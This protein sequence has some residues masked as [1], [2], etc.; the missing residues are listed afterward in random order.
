MGSLSYQP[1]AYASKNSE[2]SHDLKNI[3]RCNSQ[4]HPIF[5]AGRNTNLE[6]RALMGFAA[7]ETR[8]LELLLQ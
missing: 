2:T 3:F 8:L 1:N 7:R 6:V 5:I 4:E